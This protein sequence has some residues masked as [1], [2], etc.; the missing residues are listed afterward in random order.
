[1]EAKKVVLDT[2]FL[3]I[4]AQFRVDIFE[5][6]TKLLDDSYEL[7]TLKG[8]LGE[9]RKIQEE[10]KG[11]NKANAKLT[12]D[13]LETK[14]LNIIDHDPGHIDDIIVERADKDT[15]VC[16]QDKDLKRRLK[17]KGIKI[18]TLRQKKYLTWG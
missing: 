6:L 5:E 13:L 9:L 3:L 4:P 11:K 2:N 15:I 18:I 1:V 17:E 10:Q 16:T 12:L 7:T 8:C 14:E